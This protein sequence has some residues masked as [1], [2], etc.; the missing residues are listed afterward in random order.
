MIDVM[1][2]ETQEECVE[3]GISCVSCSLCVP[4]GAASD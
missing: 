4:V 1:G 2:Y 3:G